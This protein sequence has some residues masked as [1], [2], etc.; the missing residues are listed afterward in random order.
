MLQGG[1]MVLARLVILAW[2]ALAALSWL[3]IWPLIH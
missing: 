2:A 1:G 3:Y